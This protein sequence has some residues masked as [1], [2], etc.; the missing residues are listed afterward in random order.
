MDEEPR[1]G[2]ILLLAGV[3]DEYQLASAL[4]EQARWGHRLGVTLIKLGFVEE[5]DLVRGLAHQLNLPVAGLEGKSISPE[6]LAYVPRE[7][8]EKTMTL[9]LFRWS[10]AKKYPSSKIT[11]CRA[12]R[13]ASLW[14]FASM[15]LSS[16]V[17]TIRRPSADPR[18][19]PASS[20]W[21]ESAE[22]SEP[23]SAGLLDSSSVNRLVIFQLLRSH[24]GFTIAGFP[25][26][27]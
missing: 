15:T 3:I 26:C 2:E 7:V 25:E 13:F 12:S 20:R 10:F 1:L 11:F 6:V 4:A 22:D 8:A 17:K 19:P 23:A 21:R 14:D 24:L 9:P 18:L 5:R 16:G 27:I